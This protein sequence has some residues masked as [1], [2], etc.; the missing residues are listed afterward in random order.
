MSFKVLLQGSQFYKYLQSLTATCLSADGV[1]KIQGAVK[2][3]DWKHF[4]RAAGGKW[5][6]FTHLKY[7]YELEAFGHRQYN[8]VCKISFIFELKEMVFQVAVFHIAIMN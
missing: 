1:C 3:W 7:K 2:V 6:S 8:S 5:G 4:L